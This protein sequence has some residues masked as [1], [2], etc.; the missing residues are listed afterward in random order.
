[1]PIVLRRDKEV[2]LTF[3]ELDDNFALLDTRLKEIERETL[4]VEGIQDIKVDDGRLT[5]VGTHGRSWGPFM[6]PKFIPRLMGGWVLDQIYVF[7]DLVYQSGKT[8]MC[9]EN[10]RSVAFEEDALKW[11]LV[12]G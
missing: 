11:Q 2:P 9:K 3:Q 12:L 8:Y 7:G 10:H 5:V 4:C 6:L 1:M